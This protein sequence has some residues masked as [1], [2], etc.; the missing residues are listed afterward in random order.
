M[1]GNRVTNAGLAQFHHFPVFKTWHGGEPAMALLDFEAEPNYLGLRGSFTNEGFARLAGLNGLFA[2]NA[3]DSKLAVTSAGLAALVD[4]PNLGWLAFDA[5]DDSMP[6]I[7]AMPKLR[8]L[9]CQ[10]TVAGDD[11]FVP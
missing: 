10:D 4:L 9:M 6:Y 1:S 8:F 5:K 3:D 2:L 11:G 7:A